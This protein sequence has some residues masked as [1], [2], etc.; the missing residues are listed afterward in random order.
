MNR[1]F[2][3]SKV[4]SFVLINFDTDIAETWKEAASLNVFDVH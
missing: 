4:V 1:I 3:K 2:E